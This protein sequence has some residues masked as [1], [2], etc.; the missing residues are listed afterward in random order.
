[1]FLLSPAAAQHLSCM[2]QEELW[3]ISESDS[4]ELKL[5]QLAF[6]PENACEA[7]HLGF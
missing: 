2:N 6:Q 1:M 7:I 3:R 5:L 4:S